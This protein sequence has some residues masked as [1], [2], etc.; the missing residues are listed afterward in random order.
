MTDG[1]IEL[2]EVA[3]D[4]ANEGRLYDTELAFHECKDLQ[5]RF[6]RRGRL[7]HE[8]FTHGDN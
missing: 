7:R 4:G 2:T 6:S 3:Q 8:R 5:N 1:K